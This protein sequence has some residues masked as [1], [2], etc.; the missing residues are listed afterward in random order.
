MTEHLTETAAEIE[1]LLIG[2][3]QDVFTEIIFPNYGKATSDGVTLGP[4]WWSQRLEAQGIVMTPNAVKDRMKREK[5]RSAAESERSHAPTTGHKSVIR[6]AKSALRKHPE[7]AEKLLDDPAVRE[8]A[9]KALVNDP[10]SRH[11]IR[12]AAETAAERD[13]LVEQERTVRKRAADPVGRRMDENIALLDL[14]KVIN[15]FVREATKLLPQVGRV[16]DSER[17]WLNG[18]ADRLEAVTSEIRH[19]ADH[20][21]TRTDTELHALLGEGD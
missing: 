15:K 7:L 2:S 5:A 8:A 14:Q 17:Y 20:G 6:G 1:A 12:K 13:Y 4:T 16:V 9:T 19:L 10:Q 3:I 11:E 21:E 18:E